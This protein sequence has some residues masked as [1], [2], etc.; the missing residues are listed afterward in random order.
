MIRASTLNNERAPY[1]RKSLR[2]RAYEIRVPRLTRKERLS[3]DRAMPCKD[4]WRPKEFE[5]PSED[6][7]AYWDIYRFFPAYAEL[8]W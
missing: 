6:V 4:G 7:L 5:L 8:L 2:E 1:Y 3:L